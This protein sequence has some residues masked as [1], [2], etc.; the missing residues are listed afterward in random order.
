RTRFDELVL[1]ESPAALPDD[2]HVERLLAEA[3]S[4]RLERALDLAST[5][6][7]AFRA[8]VAFLRAAVPDLELPAIDDDALR[9]ALPELCD[10][11]RSFEELRRAPLVDVLLARFDHRARA[12]LDREAPSHL[13]VPS[14]SRVA[15]RYEE[16]RAPILA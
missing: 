14:G 8:R 11:R 4:I 9:A 16:S 5:D 1:D 15:L 12:A 3:A 10:G 7:A 2:G 6:V 13:E